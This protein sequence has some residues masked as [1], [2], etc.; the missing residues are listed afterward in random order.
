MMECGKNFKNWIGKI[1]W[2]KRGC[3]PNHGECVCDIY[4]EDVCTNYL[5]KCGYYAAGIYPSYLS[6]G[7]LCGQPPTPPGGAA[8]YFYFH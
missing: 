5:H 2:G 3:Y 8:F 1:R 4:G 6:C 7:G